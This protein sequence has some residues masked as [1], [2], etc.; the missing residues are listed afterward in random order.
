MPIINNSSRPIECSHLYNIHIFHLQYWGT[1][2]L[3]GCD[4]LVLVS[5]TDC[6]I[7][8]RWGIGVDWTLFSVDYIT[9]L[10]EDN[11]ELGN[12]V[13][14]KTSLS[15]TTLLVEDLLDLDYVMVWSLFE[16]MLELDYRRVK[17]TPPNSKLMKLLYKFNT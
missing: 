8:D 5:G 4:S 7:G 11:L 16:D 6:E 13:S 3:L 12:V 14:W 1:C 17:P 15:K 9:L 2:W 10:L